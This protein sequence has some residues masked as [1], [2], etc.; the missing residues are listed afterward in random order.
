MLNANCVL[1]IP[2]RGGF[3]PCPFFYAC[4]QLSN[5]FFCERYLFCSP[6]LYS[7]QRVPVV[8]YLI[9]IAFP[10][11]ELCLFSFDDLFSFS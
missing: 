4:M 1:T 3:S 5:E 10:S 2:I 9:N 8:L 7:Q 11:M 6:F